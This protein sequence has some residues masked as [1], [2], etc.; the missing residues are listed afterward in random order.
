MQPQGGDATAWVF[1]HPAV[2]LLRLLENATAASLTQLNDSGIVPYLA[3]KVLE[4]ATRILDDPAGKIVKV[5]DP[6]LIE[7]RHALILVVCLC[8]TIVMI[9]CAF[10]F[11]REDREEQITPLCP[12]LVVKDIDQNF[13]FPLDDQ[14]ESMTVT[15]PTKNDQTICKVVLDWPDPFRPGA[16]GVAA[17]VRI[18]NN[19]DLVLAT[20]VA[21]N[22]AVIGQGLALCRA[23]CEIFG[24]VEPEGPRRYHVR[25][26]TGVHLLTLLGDFEGGDVEGINPVGTAVCW[27]KKVGTDCQCR[28]LQHVDAGLVL[29][30][31][32]A[33]QVHRRLTTATPPTAVPAPKVASAGVRAPIRPAAAAPGPKE[34]QRL[35]KTPAG[36][37]AGSEKTAAAPS[38]RDGEASG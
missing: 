15:D 25:H 8:S 33:T 37:G 13:K 18:Q 17:T 7:S 3:D 19:L 9:I 27:F 4:N 6:C 26:R 11:F 29:S 10:I 5:E 30:S 35:S 1:R 38:P 36:L 24:F 21:R 32:L 2:M 16:S 34:Q 31:F 22:V 12:Q 28:V 23:G 14:A 20:V